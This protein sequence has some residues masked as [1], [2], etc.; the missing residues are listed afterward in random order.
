MRPV[1]R[2]AMPALEALHGVYER[3]LIDSSIDRNDGV[4]RKIADQ[5]EKCSKLWH[6]GV[7]VTG[8]NRF[9]SGRER[10]PVIFLGQFQVSMQRF[11]RPLVT[12][13]GRFD[14]RQRRRDIAGIYN[15]FLQE[16]R[17]IVSLGLN[18]KAKVKMLRID[19]ADVK[20]RDITHYAD[21]K[22]GVE[23]HGVRFRRLRRGWFEL[24]QAS[25]P[26]RSVVIL[27]GQSLLLGLK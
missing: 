8:C 25:C 16:F 26:T 6:C 27:R 21:G 2:A 5:P 11:N 10:F 23:L 12:G 18:V 1:R 9:C 7:R 15:I 22:C 4:C 19:L 24:C 14:L 17:Q 3:S 20:I 13:V